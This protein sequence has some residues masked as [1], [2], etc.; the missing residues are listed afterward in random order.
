MTS[1]HRRDMQFALCG[2]SDCGE[3]VMIW[4]VGRDWPPQPLMAESYAHPAGAAAG[5]CRSA[6]MGSSGIG[7]PGQVLP[8]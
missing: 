6:A 4:G 7:G 8:V 5:A 2:G 3:G 1:M